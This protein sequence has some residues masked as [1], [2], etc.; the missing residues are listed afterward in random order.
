MSMRERERERGEADAEGEG[1]VWVHHDIAPHYMFV[2][3]RNFEVAIFF[4]V[5]MMKSAHVFELL[6]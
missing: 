1:M 2:T 3:P 4:V 6:M 5:G